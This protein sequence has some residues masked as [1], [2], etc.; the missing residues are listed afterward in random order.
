METKE[1]DLDNNCLK[2]IA[3][4]IFSPGTPEILKSI[5]SPHAISPGP[6]LKHITD[7]VLRP[8]RIRRDITP[9]WPKPPPVL[10][11]DLGESVETQTTE[12]LKHRFQHAPQV[13]EK[14]VQTDVWA[15]TSASSE[16]EY[17]VQ[18]PGDKK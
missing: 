2:I 11:T 5:A 6:K 15:M 18:Y 9:N 17:P 12:T 1:K 13:S 3:E 16:S 10:I 8:W 7:F 4:T 14:G